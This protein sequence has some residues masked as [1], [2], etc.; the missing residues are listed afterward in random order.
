M[1]S[2]IDIRDGRLE[3]Q[4]IE[5]QAPA[6][7][8]LHE[9]LGSVG[10]WRGLPQKLHELTGLRTLAFS[11]FGHGQSDPPPRPRT[12]SFMHEEAREVL[13]QVLA[14][15]GIEQPILVGHSDGASIALIHA[16]DHPVTGLALMAPHVFVEQVCVD[17]IAETSRV[18]REDNLRE[19]MARHHRDPDAAFHGWCD[20]WLDPEFLGWNLVPLLP[21]IKTPTLL[22]QGRDDEYGTLAQV[23]AIQ[24]AAGGPVELSVVSGGHSPHLEHPDE[25]PAQ[26]ARFIASLAR[27]GAA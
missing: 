15:A 5:G 12:P 11:R 4:L 1:T 17:A 25:V 3:A 6:L 13:P 14:A 24:G 8:L 19:R 20:V 7:V 27:A 23:H 2:F 21:R 16:A 26:V 9:G 22:I 18:F 10:L